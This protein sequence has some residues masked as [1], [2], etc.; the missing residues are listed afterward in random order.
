MRYSLVYEG[1]FYLQALR[2][3]GALTKAYVTQPGMPSVASDPTHASDPL[4]TAIPIPSGEVAARQGNV[5][6][7]P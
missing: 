7:Q 6:P 4:Q 2:E 1:P 5:T 3:Y